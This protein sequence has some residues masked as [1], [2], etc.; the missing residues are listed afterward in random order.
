LRKI[1]FVLV[2]A[3]SDSGTVRFERTR[4]PSRDAALG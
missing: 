3:P 4:D 1:G 2:D